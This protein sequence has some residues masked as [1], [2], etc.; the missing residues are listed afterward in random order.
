LFPSAPKATYAAEVKG[1]QS[2]RLEQCRQEVTQDQALRQC[3]E[4]LR[5]RRRIWIRT[6]H[7]RDWPAGLWWAEDRRAKPTSSVIMSFVQHFTFE[8]AIHYLY[9]NIVLLSVRVR[10]VWVRYSYRKAIFVQYLTT[11][12]NNSRNTQLHH[13]YL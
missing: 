9:F 6:R 13:N 4:V 10:L 11:E 2:P 12:V 8:K 7:S 1:R 3:S 5:V